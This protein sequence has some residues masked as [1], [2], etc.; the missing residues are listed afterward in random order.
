MNNPDTVP[1][2]KEDLAH[3]HA[4][5]ARMSPEELLRATY[6]LE[7]IIEDS[8]WFREKLQKSAEQADAGSWT[9]MEEV[10]TDHGLTVKDLQEST[11]PAPKRSEAA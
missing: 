8:P 4:M 9:P 2:P 3:A 1:N 6:A 10:L 11:K 5:L 7:E